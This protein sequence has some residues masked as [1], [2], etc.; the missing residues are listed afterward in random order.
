MNSRWVNLLLRGLGRFH[1]VSDLV[2]SDRLPPERESAIVSRGVRLHP[3]AGANG[4]AVAVNVV[5]AAHGGPVLV[6]LEPG[7][8]ESSL[9]ARVSAIP[10]FGD[11]HLRGVP[12]IFL[13][14]LL[15]VHL[16]LL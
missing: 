13:W 15:V 12:R 11:T 10:L 7:R 4:V 3:R 16:S 14:I 5:D 6:F 2:R 8:G 1:A 9:F